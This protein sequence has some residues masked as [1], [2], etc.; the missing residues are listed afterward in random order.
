[1]KT[2]TYLIACILFCLH[3][4]SGQTLTGFWGV[5]QV[6]VGEE[7][8]TPVA[9][10]FRFAEDSSYTSGNGWLQNGAGSYHFNGDQLRPVNEFGD[11]DPYGAFTVKHPSQ[12]EMQWQRQEVGAVVTV[13]LHR[14]EE[15]P[16]SPADRIQGNWTLTAAEGDTSMANIPETIFIRW[17][18]VYRATKS[19]ENQWGLW[20]M[21]A[22]RP[23]FSLHP[24]D[25]E[26]PSQSFTAT[27]SGSERLM[28]KSD[29]GITLNYER[30]P[31]H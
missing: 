26:L 13:H 25:R 12:S 8:M 3:P 14:I 22:H 4:L 20:R 24:F 31:L 30:T 27:F 6:T 23:E 18:Q 11:A 1:M 19:G 29:T 9:K 5:E 28:L 17:D 10:W 7:V 15:L 2:K 16:K 21:H